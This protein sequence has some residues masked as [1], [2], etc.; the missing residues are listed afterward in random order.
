VNLDE[1][2]ARWRSDLRSS[3]VGSDAARA[4]AIFDEMTARYSEAHR[5]YHTLEHIAEVL[6]HVDELAEP[7]VELVAVCLAAWAHDVIY[8]PHRSDNEAA[9]AVWTE[10]VLGSVDAP[11][12]LIAETCR[13]IALT[14]SHQAE[15]DD[16]RGRL[17]ADADLAILGAPAERYERYAADIRTEYS[18]VP[19]NEFR[20]GRGRV[21]EEFVSRWAIFSTE[22]ARAAYEQRARDNIARELA[23]LSA[24][25]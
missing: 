22:R 2:R 14:A 3:S 10:R 24:G 16:A 5:R 13:L 21:L 7:D 8:D 11:E 15:D 20:E 19:E 4:D 18:F 1:L 25:A 6:Q 12:G 9:S 17:L 23:I